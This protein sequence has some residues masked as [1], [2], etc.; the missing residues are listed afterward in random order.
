ML[1]FII[2]MFVGSVFG[3]TICAICSADKINSR[4]ATQCKKG[5]DNAKN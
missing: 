4:I 5:E 2:G 1:Q 3:F